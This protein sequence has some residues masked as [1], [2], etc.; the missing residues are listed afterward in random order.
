MTSLIDDYTVEKQCKYKNEH[1]SVRD[2]GALLRLPPDGKSCRKLD[3]QWTF[4][5]KDEKTGY[6]Y[7]G[8]HRVHI[9]V[10]TAFAGE[11]DS[12]K[13][14]VDHIDTNRC[15]N[16]PENLRWL[17]RLENALLN[18][19]TLKKIIYLCGSVEAFIKDPTC[20]R[21]AA[22]EN[23]DIAWMRTVSKEEAQSSYKRICDWSNNYSKTPHISHNA[24]QG[25]DNKSKDWVFTPSPHQYVADTPEVFFTKAEFPESAIQKNWKTPTR[26]PCCPTED[27]HISLYDYQHNAHPGSLFSENAYCRHRVVES[28]IVDNGTALAIRTQDENE[29]A[30]KRHS[31][32]VVILSGGQFI[33][34]CSTFFSEIGAQKEM[35]VRQGMEWNGP[36]CIDDYC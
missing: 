33:H 28:A 10:A 8:S 14:I 1:Y 7:I 4:G 26:F 15:N 31:V 25:N 27:S 6:M 35:I 20:L 34:E 16:R 18:P 9:I 12:T 19:A 13:F 24:N 32:T 23:Q 21:I 2:N 3:N 5:R 22:G 36:D 29:H 17:T 11:H 30:L